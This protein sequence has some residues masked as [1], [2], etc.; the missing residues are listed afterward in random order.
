MTTNQ[1]KFNLNAVV[2]N[3][4]MINLVHPPKPILIEN[5][6]TNASNNSLYGRNQNL[7]NSNRRAHQEFE[8][9][10]ETKMSMYSFLIERDL[11][12]KEWLS[13]YELEHFN[14][15]RIDKSK[16]NENKEPLN[17]KHKPSGTKTV[18]TNSTATT[19]S[20]NNNKGFAFET[21]KTVPVSSKT[22]I[23][24]NLSIHPTKSTNDLVEIKKCC[25]DTVKAMENL[26]NQLNECEFKIY[27]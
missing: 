11:K 2:D 5:L 17:V 10:D 12:T 6:H 8:Y 23:R 24:T 9:I 25:D 21:K 13:K 16:T 4:N 19:T 18:T 20:S 7:Y 26:E 22:S 1:L 27:F 14:E 3:L 15:S